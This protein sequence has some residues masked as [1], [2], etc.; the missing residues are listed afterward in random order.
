MRGVAL[1]EAD[2]G[3]FPERGEGDALGAPR[4]RGALTQREVN[5]SPFTVCQAQTRDIDRT[6]VAGALLRA[7]GEV[8]RLCAAG[9]EAFLGEAA[10]DFRAGASLKLC[11]TCTS[12]PLRTP[13]CNAARSEFSNSTLGTS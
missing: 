11:L 13:F 4:R 8:L 2:R 1:L 12:S 9:V 6:H 5:I 3:V 7:E 10:G